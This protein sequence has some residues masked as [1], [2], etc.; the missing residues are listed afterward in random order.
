MSGVGEN[1]DPR[2]DLLPTSNGR[3]TSEGGAG[4]TN[5]T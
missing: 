1:D 3:P 4:R 5:S 2:V